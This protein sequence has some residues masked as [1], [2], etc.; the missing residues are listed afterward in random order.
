MVG[1]GRAAR[2]NARQLPSLGEPSGVVIALGAGDLIR[3]GERRSN[4]FLG[5]LPRALGG[6]G[7]KCRLGGGGGEWYLRGEAC[8]LLRRLLDLSWS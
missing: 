8:S 7:E 5:D 1:P 2:L 4:R 6:G 3:R